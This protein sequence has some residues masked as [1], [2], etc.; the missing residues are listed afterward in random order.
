M[1]NLT[2]KQQDLLSQNID[3]A[4]STIMFLLDHFEEN[5]HEFK[6]TGEITHNQLWLVQTLLE[7]AQK[8]MRGGE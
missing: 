6:F 7:N 3:Q 4:H 1:A 8:A 5:D 2:L